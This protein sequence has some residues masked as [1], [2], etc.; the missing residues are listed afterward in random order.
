MDTS[1]VA[2]P[3]PDNTLD[4]HYAGLERLRPHGCLGGVVYI[5]HMQYDDDSGEE[6]EVYE[7]LPCRR[8]ATHEEL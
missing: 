8:C 7:A 2:H 5:G 1:R 3:D 6:V 4:A